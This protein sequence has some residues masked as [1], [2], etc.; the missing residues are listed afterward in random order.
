MVEAIRSETD[1]V[2][3]PGLNCTARLFEPQIA[4]LRTRARIAVADHGVA[5]SL[6]A[7]AV[8]VLAAA[9]PRFA[10]A[11]LSM[12]GYV[13]YEMMRQ[14]PERIT[15]LALLDTRVALDSE[16]AKADRRRLI[17]LADAG[18]IEDIHRALWPHLV[19][20][21]RLTDAVLE[22]CVRT[23]AMET[24]GTR[25]IRQQRAIM[26]RGDYRVTVS[27]IG[28]PTL[29]LVGAEDAI[30]PVA[31]AEELAGLIAGA[32]LTVVPSCGHLSTLERPDAVTAALM[33]WLQA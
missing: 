32:T 23:M 20:P 5:D 6:P 22:S 15:R 21:A 33:R 11:G 9:P 4:A 24:G 28:V 30:T 7:I 29:V 27:R 8:H 10:L 18:R 3:V 1:L 31:A 12:G 17:A 19:H 13:A 16:A 26:A 2:L 25:F 14:A